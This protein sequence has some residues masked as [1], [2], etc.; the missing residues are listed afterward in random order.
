MTLVPGM[1]E[2][3]ISEGVQDNK[4]RSSNV[5][6]PIKDTNM[7]RLFRENSYLQIDVGSMPNV[8]LRLTNSDVY[9]AHN[10]TDQ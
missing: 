4:R 8:K 10:P 1:L 5:S 6:A 9:F 2:P 7:E 3:S